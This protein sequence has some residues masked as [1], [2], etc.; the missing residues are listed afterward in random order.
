MHHKPSKTSPAP[1]VKLGEHITV[2]RRKY[3][4]SQSMATAKHKHQR[5]VFNPANQ[6]L[7]EFLDELRKL[8]KNAFGVAAPAINEQFIYTEKPPHLKKPI[9]QPLVEKSTLEQIVSHLD[10]EVEINGLEAQDAMHVNTVTHEATNQILRNPNRHVITAKSRA[11]TEPV[12]LTQ[13]RE[14]SK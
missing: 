3:V 6:K 10:G 7:V 9:Y 2:F 13:Q 12:S 11:T 4:K 1:R 14:R 5:L 8:A